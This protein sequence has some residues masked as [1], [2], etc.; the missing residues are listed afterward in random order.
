VPHAGGLSDAGFQPCVDA[1]NSAIFA[2][3]CIQGKHQHL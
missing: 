3:D 2:I 1:P